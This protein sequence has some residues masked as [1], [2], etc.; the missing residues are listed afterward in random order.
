MTNRLAF[1]LEAA[2]K[3]GRATL[4]YFQTGVQ[5]DSKEDDSPVTVADREAERLLRTEIARR[6]PEDAILGE[7]EGSSG[8]GDDRWV[9]DPI[10]G[11]KSFISGVPLFATLLSYERAGQPVIGVCYLPA[12]NEMIY[13]EA[14]QGAYW[15]GR[16]CR[17]SSH[18]TLTG[19]TLSSAG[20]LG[21]ERRGI[22][23]GF[24]KAAERAATTRTWCDA[25][26]HALV[27]TGRVEAMI[28]PSIKRWDVSAMGVI[29]REAGGTFTDLHGCLDLGD[30]AISSNGLVHAELLRSL[31]G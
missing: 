14:G 7:E 5:V 26:G 18:A 17:V 1:A 9:I 16:P 3:A 28:D 6:Y 30:S 10:D 19:C 22:M 29:V 12:L 21:I 31:Q 15:N 2:T 4:A 24:M 13:A 8:E 20:Y 23:E 27:A 25:Y 11:T